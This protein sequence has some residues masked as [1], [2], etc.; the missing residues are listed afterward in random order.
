LF[1]LLVTSLSDRDIFDVWC[2]FFRV[3]YKD[4][5]EELYRFGIFQKAIKLDKTEDDLHPNY[6]ILADYRDEELECFCHRYISKSMVD[7]MMQ[8]AAYLARCN[9]PDDDDDDE[10]P[11][12][13]I[14]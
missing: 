12:I 7:E 6:P 9:A 8:Y 14:W 1:V 5:E 13:L 10:C 2:K 3:T 4:E 11:E